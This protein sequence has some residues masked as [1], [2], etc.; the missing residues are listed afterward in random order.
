LKSLITLHESIVRNAGMLVGTDV[1]RDLLTI[2]SRFR[3]EGESFLTITLPAFCR[4]FERALAD[5]RS[6]P[7]LYPGFGSRLGLPAFLRGF[8]ELIFDSRTGC[9]LAQPSTAAI[10]AVRQVTLVFS[11]LFEVCDSR[12]EKAT[13]DGFVE[14]ERTLETHPQDLM[15]ELSTVLPRY[16]GQSLSDID[17]AVWRGELL[18]SH[19]PGVTADRIT[20]NRKFDIRRWTARLDEWFPCADHCVPS[21]G[22]FDQLTQIQWD[23]PGTEIPVKVTSVPKTAAKARIIA[24]EPTHM[25][26]AQQGLLR[27]FAHE[28]SGRAPFVDLSDQE[29]NQELARQGSMNGGIATIDLSEASDRVTLQLVRAVFHRYPHLLGALEACRSTQARL[30]WGQ[31]IDLRKFASMGSAVCFPVE[32]LCFLAVVLHAMEMTANAAG[33]SRSRVKRL[34][35]RLRVFGDDIAVPAPIV[36]ACLHVLTSLGMRVNA[37]KSFWNGHF[38]ESCGR[39]YFA[40]DDVTVAR[41]RK[42]LPSDRRNAVEVAGLVSFRNH[43]YSRGYW[44]TCWQIDEWIGSNIGPLPIVE[45]TSSLLGRYSVCFTEP[46]QRW[47]PDYQTPLVRGMYIWGQPPR[48]KVGTLGKLMK[49]LTPLKVVPFEDAR[50]LQRYGRP[51][52]VHIKCGWRSPA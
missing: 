11:R 7:C 19:G 5:G 4:G 2:A 20:G 52:T 1:E 50:H 39:E 37:T 32:S 9:I 47:H 46:I 49:C 24:I 13:L 44:G 8:L 26:Y 23:E 18:C 16:V 51:H 3:D 14:C 38:R 15:D 10:Q 29:P 31:I 43:L 22:Y 6:L 12:R 42:R 41:L 30:P 28:F 21:Y 25:Q 34:L 48:S 27:L 35:T 33:W 17:A 45:Q 36:P 40:G